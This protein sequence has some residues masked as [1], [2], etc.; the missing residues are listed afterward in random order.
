MDE[1]KFKVCTYDNK[2]PSYSTVD[3]LNG[4]S[5]VYLDTTYNQATRMTLRQEEHFIVKNVSQYQQPRIIFECNLKNSLNIKP[6]TLLTDKTLSGKYFIVDTMEIDYR[7]N[8][9][10]AQIIE[11]TNDYQ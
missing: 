8:K 1:I 7:Q 9:V 4:S 11:K 2:T 3:Y 6:W 10:T 5:S